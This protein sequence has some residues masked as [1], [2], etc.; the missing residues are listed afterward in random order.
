MKMD[1]ISLQ[2]RVGSGN[3]VRQIVRMARGPDGTRGFA[4][5]RGAPVP[6]AEELVSI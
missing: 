3:R 1:G 2:K 5:G 6:A 4:A